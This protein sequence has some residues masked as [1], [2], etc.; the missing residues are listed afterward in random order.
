M[1]D[2]F[3][4]DLIPVRGQTIERG[5]VVYE[6]VRFGKGE[7]DLK[8]KKLRVLETDRGSAT[9]EPYDGTAG[10]KRAERRKV[11]LANLRMER[12][13]PTP[14]FDN[15]P[16]VKL[17]PPA[18]DVPASSPKPPATPRTVSGDDQFEAW[19][20]MG[21]ELLA[22]I[23]GE[24]SGLT[25]QLAKIKADLESVDARHRRTIEELEQE[26]V[27]ARRAHEED[28]ALAAARK[29]ALESKL[30]RAKERLNGIRLM[31]GEGS[32]V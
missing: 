32:D 19:A 8:L 4:Q 13:A 21:R 7:S 1:T 26:L 15:P 30:E 14:K 3:A 22:G 9:V 10:E 5:D 29:E 18:N 27:E 17:V 16:R 28:R 6:L 23:T 20:E 12:P 31:L 25:E 24:I 11:Q 2:A